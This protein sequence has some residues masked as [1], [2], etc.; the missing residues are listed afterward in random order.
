MDDIEKRP[1]SNMKE[2]VF[3]IDKDTMRDL[4]R[5]AE[6][7]NLTLTNVINKA[8]YNFVRL[9]KNHL[10]LDDNGVNDTGEGYPK[11]RE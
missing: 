6:L 7:K 2:Y 8:L 11:E 3:Y 5:I 4:H 9:Y 10:K 1:P